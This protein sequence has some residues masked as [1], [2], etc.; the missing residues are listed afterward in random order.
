M[1]STI[2]RLVLPCGLLLVLVSACSSGGASQAGSG[3]APTGR[4]IVTSEDLERSPGQT[5]E[6]VLM[7][8]V[9]GI[10]VTRGQDGSLAI[11]IRGPSSLSSNT[12]PL[13]IVDGA[14]FAAG[15]GGTLSGINPFDISSIEVLKDAASTT[16][17]GVRGA[18]G[19]IVIKLKHGPQ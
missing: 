8:K 9:P 11:Q 4:S 14:P 12:D 6:S 13:F 10:L 2:T 1:R 7:S 3:P 5:V 19:V 17:Y 18:N 16:M 15:P